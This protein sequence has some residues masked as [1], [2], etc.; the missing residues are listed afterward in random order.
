MSHSFGNTLSRAFAF[1][2]T[3]FPKFTS[4]FW[5]VLFC[6]LQLIGVALISTGVI[7]LSI[8]TLSLFIPMF[9]DFM[10]GMFSDMI[11]SLGL[12]GFF[13]GVLFI[14]LGAILTIIFTFF[15]NGFFVRSCKGKDMTL[16][17]PWKM[18]GQGF[19]SMVLEIVYFLPAAIITFLLY[20]GPMT[21]T[22]YYVI[23][24]IIVPI[25]LFI[26][27]YMFYVMAVVRYAKTGKFGKAF[28]IPTIGKI[29]CSA[30][31]IRFIWFCIVFFLII[32]LVS[33]VFYIVPLVG[34][35]MYLFVMPFLIAFEGGFFSELYD[36]GEEYIDVKIA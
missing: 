23:C 27:T 28:Q 36:S 17:H 14:V 6:L 10:G 25:L 31:W 30:G 2:N 9:G 4:W 33:V 35:I 22:I 15:V 12:L 13:F 7:I 16:S 29:I 26:V 3:A 24:G 5:I 21:D 18:F 11:T 34:A 1:A 32:I 8:S 20:L 19:L